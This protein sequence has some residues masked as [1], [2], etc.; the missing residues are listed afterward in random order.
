[1]LVFWV[2]PLVRLPSKLKDSN[3]PHYLLL[4]D[5]SIA[6]FIPFTKAL[7]LCEMQSV[8]SGVWSRVTESIFY[9]DINY[10]TI[11]TIFCLMASKQPW[12]M[13][14]EIYPGW[15]RVWVQFNPQF[16]AELDSFLPQAY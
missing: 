7:T 11:T 5:V 3:L 13:Q 9:D 1:M 15:K 8:L 12:V 16:L 10:K 14:Y 6:G 2:L 4:K